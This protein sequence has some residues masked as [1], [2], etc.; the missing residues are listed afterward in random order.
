MITQL[1]QPADLL[2]LVGQD[3]GTGQWHAI[4]QHQV[5][6]FADATHDHQWIHVE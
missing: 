2:G 5:N 6:I 3:I 4:T 1:S